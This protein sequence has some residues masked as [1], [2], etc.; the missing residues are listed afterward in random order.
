MDT[1]P[2]PVTFGGGSVISSVPVRA[3]H[4][5]HERRGYRRHVHRRECGR[6]EGAHQRQRRQVWVA[7]YRTR[8]WVAPAYMIRILNGRYHQVL[9]QEGYFTIVLIPGHYEWTTV[10]VWVPGRWRCGY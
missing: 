1:G 7:G 2:F 6:V 4:R 9:L 10:S 8:Q 5:V 3:A